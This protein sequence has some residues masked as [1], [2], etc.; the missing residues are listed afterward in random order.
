MRVRRD[1][2]GLSENDGVASL[3]CVCVEVSVNKLFDISLC[4]AQGGAQLGLTMCSERAKDWMS[5]VDP[6][7]FR[8]ARETVWVD[9]TAAA[10]LLNQAVESRLAIGWMPEPH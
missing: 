7:P 9:Y 6:Q 4:E 3:V 2:R 1:G 10:P 5:K 8:R